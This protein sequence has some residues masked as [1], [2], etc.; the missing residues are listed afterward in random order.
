MPLFVRNNLSAEVEAAQLLLI[1]REYEATSTRQALLA[2]LTSAEQTLQV[3]RQAWAQ[4]E[5]TGGQHLL[6]KEKLLGRLWEA[7]E[8]STADYLVQLKQSLDTEESVIRQRAQLW[9]SWTQ[10]LI[11]SGDIA[12]WISPQSSLQTNSIPKKLG[13]GE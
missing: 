10:W 4:W 3:N 13:S 7:G 1:Q 5:A 9:Q 8:L 12:K 2:Q 11:A 6:R